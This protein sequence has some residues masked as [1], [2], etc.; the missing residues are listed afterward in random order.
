MAASAYELGEL[1]FAASASCGQENVN[2]LLKGLAALSKELRRVNEIH[3]ASRNLYARLG[4]LKPHLGLGQSNG[5]LTTNFL[6]DG[7]GQIGSLWC[8][9]GSLARGFSL[10][11][12]Q[13]GPPVEV[14]EPRQAARP[15][16]RATN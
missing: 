8:L 12:G 4:C 5:E 3:Q 2:G 10:V 7:L 11:L 13:G 9:S 16:Q 1:R 6:S 14:N 15:G